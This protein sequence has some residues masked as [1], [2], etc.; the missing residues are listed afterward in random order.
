MADVNVMQFSSMPKH[1]PSGLSLYAFRAYEP[2]LQRWLTQDPIGES[3]GINLYGFV[4]NDPLGHGDPLG[5]SW[6]DYIPGI[7]PGAA[8]TRGQQAIQNWLNSHSY[9]SLQDF[10]QQTPRSNTS[11]QTANNLDA[12]N[13]V[14][15]LAGGATEGYI[16]TMQVLAGSSVAAKAEEAAA[17]KMGEAEGMF[18]KF[19][20][21]CKFWKKPAKPKSTIPKNHGAYADTSKS[22]TC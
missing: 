10:D 21:K 17:S 6:T 4:R 15:N 14:G 2:N 12:I 8:Q 18:S 13:G 1:P 19:W 16:N 9:D 7:G 3:G 5:L 22:G 20:K 11:G